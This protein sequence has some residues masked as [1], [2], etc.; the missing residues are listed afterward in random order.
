MARQRKNLG[1][2]TKEPK[3]RNSSSSNGSSTHNNNTRASR[4]KSILSYWKQLAFVTVLGV[5]VVFGVMGYLQTRVN[6]PFDD[7]KVSIV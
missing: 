4:P 5:T 3:S 2:H 6:T 1:E 7:K